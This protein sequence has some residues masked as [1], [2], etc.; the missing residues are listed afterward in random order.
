MLLPYVKCAL[1]VTIASDLAIE[2]TSMMFEI[3][4]AGV[5]V[6]MDIPHPSLTQISLH[7]AGPGVLWRGS[8]PVVVSYLAKY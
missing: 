8:G 6:G 7:Q 1:H 3:W 4:D 2:S 5:G